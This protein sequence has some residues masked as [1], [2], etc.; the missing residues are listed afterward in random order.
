MSKKI[1][2]ILVCSLILIVTSIIIVVAIMVKN[3]VDEDIEMRQQYENKGQVGS[4]FFEDEFITCNNVKIYNED[5]EVFYGKTYI[6]NVTYAH[7]PLVEFFEKIG[8][9][10][11][12]R[13][14]NIAVIT[15]QNEK[16]I[17]NLRNKTFT[18]KGENYNMMT[19]VP[20]C[21]IFYCCAIENDIIVD[22]DTLK[23]ILDQI[24][25]GCYFE[26][27]IANSVIKIER[28]TY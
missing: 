3:S 18:K 15:F 5:I 23:G 22:G 21:E 17:L 24:D 11:N 4:L 1:S 19:P 14:K 13:T 25:F 28:K 10:I 12:W 20:G 27:D 7:I 26:Y 2:V 6:V 9:S 8:A 16:Y